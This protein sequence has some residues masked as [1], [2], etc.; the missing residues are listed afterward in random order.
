MKLK[1]RQEGSE[2]IWANLDRVKFPWVISNVLSNAVRFAPTGSEVQVVLTDRNGSVEVQVIDDGP[3]V[4]E[5]D[6]RRMFEPFFQ[7]TQP[8]TSGQK[9]LFGV[10]LTIAREVVEAH[11]GRIEY[12]RRQPHGSEFRILLPFPPA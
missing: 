3:G 2:I 12:Y 7:S 5:E 8:T 6:Q 4:S 10:G 11:D 9:G 1:F